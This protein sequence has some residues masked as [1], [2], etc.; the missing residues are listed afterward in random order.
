[1]RVVM[2]GLI[3]SLQPHGGISRLFNEILPRLCALDEGLEVELLTHGGLLQPPPVHPRIHHRRLWPVDSWLRPRRWWRRVA[4]VFRAW[5]QRRWLG[6]AAGRVWHS[7][8]YTEPLNWDGP[9]VVTVVDMIHERF[10]HLFDS[11]ADDEFRRL[12]RRCLLRA[13]VIICIS[14]TTQ[15]DLQRFYGD[16]P[17]E[18]R[19]IPLACSPCFRP[20]PQV[21]AAAKPFLLYVGERSH[22]KNFWGFLEAYRH[23]PG[24]DDVEMAVVGRPWWPGEAERLKALELG[25]HV[26][27][28]GPVN[29]EM[30]CRLYN[31]A[32]ALV[33][34]SLYEGFGIPL[35][36]AMA[37]GCPIL[38]SDIPA[39]REVAAD[40]PV[41]F[42]PAVPEHLLAALDAVMA[43]GREPQRRA[44][45]FALVQRYSWEHTARQTLAVYR[46]LARS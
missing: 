22:Y 32:S 37:C 36:E 17:G 2:D 44:R 33:Y 6:P 38:A 1:M 30:L 14:E 43:N 42:D 10:T 5:I 21:D 25:G 12:K 39:T 26:R 13:D 45:G 18:V 41:Y 8:Y 46:D 3:Y 34:P 40:Y 27:F 24:R 28:L 9:I 23:W 19:V 4:P 7:T 35:L 20:L 16:L 31:Q 11:A 15:Q 29:D